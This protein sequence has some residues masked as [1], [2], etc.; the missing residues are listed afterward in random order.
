[1]SV[2]DFGGGILAGIQGVQAFNQ[3]RRVNAQNERRLDQQDQQLAISRE[4]LAEQIRQFDKTTE[5]ADRTYEFEREKWDAGAEQRAA[6]LE[7]RLIANGSDA[8]KLQTEQLTANLTRGTLLHT[9]LSP[10]ASED[11]PFTF[12]M[13]RVIAERP[14]LAADIMTLNPALTYY[15]DDR[16]NRIQ[17]TDP[18]LEQLPN[19][20]RYAITVRKPDGTRVPV[21]ENASDNPNDPVATF[22][23]DEVKGFLTTTINTYTPNS[24]QRQR[25]Q[26][27]TAVTNNRLRL[28]ITGQLEATPMGEN[29]AASRGIQRIVYNENTSTEDLETIARDLGVDVEALKQDLQ[30]EP[31]QVR[32]LRP[33]M[34]R[35]G[36]KD[37]KSGQLIQEVEGTK[38]PVKGNPRAPRRTPEGAL[39][40]LNTYKR[41]LETRIR[42]TEGVPVRRGTNKVAT[43]QQL[44]DK[45]DEQVAADKAELAQIND[46]LAYREGTTVIPD[47]DPEQL[48]SRLMAEIDANPP[49]EEDVREVQQLLRSKNI[50]DPRQL[51]TLPDKEAYKAIM[52]AAAREPDATKRGAII[53]QLTNIITTGVS[54]QSLEQRNTGDL[55]AAEYMQ[56][57]R[58]YYAERGDK[59]QAQFEK[60]E[61]EVADATKRAEKV[62]KGLVDDSGRYTKPTTEAI[63]TL[64]GIAQEYANLPKGSMKKEALAP[65]LMQTVFEYVAAA[66]KESNPGLFEF[67]Q[68]IDKWKATP[69]RLR[70]GIDGAASL[71]RVA[72]NG[73]TVVFKNPNGGDATYR[74]PASEFRRY[75]TDPLYREVIKVARANTDA[76]G[77]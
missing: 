50:T 19:S 6:D 53:D 44:Q 10:Y 11:D 51:A 47:I 64:K 68:K 59:A 55:R 69:G 17:L 48:R 54:N 42:N 60:F 27:L 43:M 37:S 73:K 23:K 45:R 71:I 65:V 3:Q 57:V 9:Q 67:M 75:L 7:S 4:R 24:Q 63:V 29:P 32:D 30:G 13:E 20:D 16:G 15:R 14:D 1:M 33:Y 72:D 5:Q 52:I 35:G 25:F 46:Y 77:G 58:R 39:T 26:D 70:I 49:T 34:F 61:S 38:E 2:G 18:R 40:A 28:A 62:Y 12:D 74:I 22:T 76:T 31:E 41:Q 66:A 8:L 21:T 56:S 36:D